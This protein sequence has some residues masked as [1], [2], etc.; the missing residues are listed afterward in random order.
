VRD[1][2]MAFTSIFER[3]TVRARCHTPLYRGKQRN[4]ARFATI[5]LPDGRVNYRRRP[6]VVRVE[7]VGVN[8]QRYIGFPVA[9]PAAQRHDV[10][11]AGYHLRSMGMP[12]GVERDVRH[13]DALGE[14][15]PV[16]GDG[17]WPQWAAV[18]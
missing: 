1:F 8:A 18:D 15:S 3:V 6:A 13:A 11:T 7:H 14:R 10:Q 4:G 17:A 2:L 16:A 5:L 12:K 9:E